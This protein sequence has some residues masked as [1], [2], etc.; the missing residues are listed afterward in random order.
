[1]KSIKKVLVTGSE[2]FIGSEVVKYLLNKGIKVNAFIL[3]NF[4]NDYGYLSRIKHKNLKFF[5]GDIRDEKT[6]ERALENSK[7]IIN[8]AALIGIPYSYEAPKSYLETNVYGTLNLLNIAI[9]KNVKKFIHTSTSEVYGTAQYVPIDEMHPL[10]AQSPYAASKIAADQLVDSFYKS[11][12]IQTT[13]IRPF[14]TF[15]PKQSMRAIIPTIINQAINSD[16]II[17]GNV[18]TRRD[19]T[20]INDTAKA[21]YCALNLSPKFSGMTFNLGTGIDFSILE[22][23]KFVS[24]ILNKK[25][26]IKIN[27]NRIRPKKSEVLILRSKNKLAHE[28]LKWEPDYNGKSGFKRGLVKTIKYIKLNNNEF[29]KLKSSKYF[30]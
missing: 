18:D 11:F 30:T 20:Y 1:M 25:L 2:G 8:L 10:N 23:I 15:G 19:F 26:K 21:F 4:Q 7:Y 24:E 28:I 9:K 12:G 29:N 17:L 14:N 5:F 22:I 13:I 3:Y 16:T 6:I 27:K